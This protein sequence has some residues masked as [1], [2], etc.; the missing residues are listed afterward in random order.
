M[1]PI[2]TPELRRGSA[3]VPVRESWFVSRA[4]TDGGVSDAA[5]AAAGDADAVAKHLFSPATL[6]CM[7]TA[8]DDHTIALVH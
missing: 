2:R 1:H 6:K 3:P 5:A 8:R 7:T 4:E